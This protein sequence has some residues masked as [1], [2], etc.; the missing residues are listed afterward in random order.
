MPGTAGGHEC[1]WEGCAGRV[2]CQES[3]VVRLRVGG[4]TA[5]ISH[6]PPKCELICHSCMQTFTFLFCLRLHSPQLEVGPNGR[7]SIILSHLWGKVEASSFLVV[8][9]GCLVRSS[10][11]PNNP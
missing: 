6:G 7:E 1:G 3:K 5:C 8:S 10:L 4:A 2:R 9:G 11:F